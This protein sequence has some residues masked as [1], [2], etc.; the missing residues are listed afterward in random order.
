MTTNVSFAW[1]DATV[2]ELRRR[3]ADGESASQ[4]GQ[5]LGCSRNAVIGKCV[6]SKPRIRLAGGTDQDNRSSPARTLAGR[7]VTGK[8]PIAAARTPKAPV[9]R[10]ATPS[11]L[12]VLRSAPVEVAAAKAEEYLSS[13]ARKH[14]FDPAHAPK[15][16]KLVPLVDLERGMCKWPLFEDGPAVFCGC[17]VTTFDQ[18]GQPDRYCEPHREM[19]RPMVGGR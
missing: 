14:A 2:A 7:M 15:G 18:N 3:A 1:T 10:V 17:Q 9:K 13:P 12:V 6:R 4:I 5:A 16:A 11:S 19:S 8:T